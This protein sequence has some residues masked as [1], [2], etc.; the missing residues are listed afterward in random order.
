YLDLSA[1]ERRSIDKHYGLGRNCH[2]FEITRKWAYRAIRQGW[3]AFSQW[4]D[5]V[6]QRVEMY[7]ASLPVPLSLAECRA[8][9]KSIAKYTHRKFSP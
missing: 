5:A 2:L 7:N 9:G 6:I 3:P 4:L 1:S 8:I